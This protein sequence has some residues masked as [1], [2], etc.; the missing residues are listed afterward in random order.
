DRGRQGGGHGGSLL[1][2]RGCAGVYNQPDG[3]RPRPARPT[4]HPH[5]KAPMPPDRREDDAP[6][7]RPAREADE[8]EADREEGEGDDDGGVS[9]LI[10]YKNG[11]ALAAYYCGIFGLIPVV[12]L[13]LGP[14][15]ML[16]GMLGLRKALQM[17]QSKGTGH[18]IAGII[19]CVFDLLAQVAYAF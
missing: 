6:R 12:G 5:R 7:R 4:P 13:L 15:A 1:L 18:A 2:D 10:P 9:T 19:L 3:R 8:A 11:M 14:L 16:F 17:P